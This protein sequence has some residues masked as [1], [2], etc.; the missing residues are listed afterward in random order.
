MALRLATL[1]AAARVA[2]AVRVVAGRVVAF[3][4]A[5]GVRFAAVAVFFTARRAVVCVAVVFL[6]SAVFFPTVF[7][8]VSGRFATCLRPVV[9]PRAVWDL[10]TVFFADALFVA[11]FA[12]AVF[13]ALDT[14]RATIASCAA[15]SAVRAL[16]SASCAATAASRSAATRVPAA[17]ASAAA[18][19]GV[20]VFAVAVAVA[21]FAARWEVSFRPA[22]AVFAA[23][24]FVAVT[25]PLRPTAVRVARPEPVE[26]AVTREAVAF[27]AGARF[28]GLSAA[29]RRLAVVVVVVA[30]AAVAR[31]A[32]VFAAV[33]P[34]AAPVAVLALRARVA[35]VFVAARV[36]VRVAAAFFAGTAL[37]TVLRAETPLLT[38]AIARAGRGAGRVVALLL[39]AIASPPRK[40]AADGRPVDS[41]HH[42]SPSWRPWRGRPRADP[43]PAFPRTA[44][45][46]TPQPRGGVTDQH[47]SP[48]P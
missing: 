20:V 13:R 31:R 5:A 19:A 7:R 38:A 43:R 1:R 23:V 47:A 15:F 22:A 14:R 33:V 4:A 32:E 9:P 21:F 25:A 2:L 29:G 41:A 16:L 46:N 39:T 40:V 26:R 34:R 45:T 28:V 37:V 42:L 24:D 12:G 30:V 6:A 18:L 11:F 3:F 36:G 44:R 35:V 10:R 27:F 48:T 8:A 17:L